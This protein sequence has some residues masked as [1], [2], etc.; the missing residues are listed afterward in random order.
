[1][2]SI[3]I[4]KGQ[5][6]TQG[7]Q[8]YAKA[9]GYDTSKI[10]KENWENTITKLE[11]IQR[12][13]KEENQASIYSTDSTKS[14]WQGKMVVQEGAIEFS[15]G[16]MEA[17]LATMGLKTKAEGYE[18][19]TVA[20]AKDPVKQHGSFKLNKDG[21][22]DSE[23]FNKELETLANDYISL[24]DK[25]GDGKISYKEFENYEV[26]QTNKAEPKLDRI[27]FEK[28][29]A[30][31]KYTFNRLNVDNEKKSKDLLDVKEIMNYF[32]SMSSLDDKNFATDGYVS[33]KEYVMMMSA[34]ADTSEAEG[35][36]GSLIAG[37]LKRNFEN[38]FKTK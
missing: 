20:V 38:L 21:N 31:L 35:S 24:Y 12:D 19:W 14:G 8:A 34:L 15:D 3:S 5:G 26:A 28:A 32:M 23:V 37:F 9:Q 10:T 13:R 2:V 7:L 1:M 29:K 33:Q 6:L 27:A 11:Y 36:Q 16:E 4:G 18:A 22:T 17:L 30:T 25:D